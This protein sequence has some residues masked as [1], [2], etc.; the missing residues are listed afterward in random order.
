VGP[1]GLLD[2][3][4]H[5]GEIEAGLFG[6]SVQFLDPINWGPDSLAV[7]YPKETVPKTRTFFRCRKMRPGA[8]SRGISPCFE[9]QDYLAKVLFLLYD[10]PRA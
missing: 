1:C 2:R 9:R 3:P 4:P 7:H 6:E 10:E 5:A 8:R